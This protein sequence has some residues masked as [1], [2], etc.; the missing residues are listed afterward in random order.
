M[1]SLFASLVPRLTRYRGIKRR[2]HLS[3]GLSVR[4]VIWDENSGYYRTLIGNPLPEVK[5]TS[6]CGPVTTRNGVGFE[7]FTSSIS[8]KC[9]WLVTS[10][11]SLAIIISDIYLPKTTEETSEGGTGVT[12]SD[13][14]SSTPQ[15]S[16]A[17]YRI[18]CRSRKFRWNY[19]PPHFSAHDFTDA[20]Y[21]FIGC[22]LVVSPISGSGPL[23]HLMYI[24]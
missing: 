22:W 3:V 23:L 13:T 19:P 10:G 24:I 14:I 20:L 15:I 12:Q 16:E 18:G 21:F 11:L 5:L 7:H 2:C 4:L 9:E 1:F 8:I 17:W 6:P